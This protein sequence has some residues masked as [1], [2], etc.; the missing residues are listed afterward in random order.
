MNATPTPSPSPAEQ[1]P[2]TELP[3]ATAPQPEPSVETEA[4]VVARLAALK[5]MDYDRLR[6]EEAKALGIQVKTLDDLVKAA[7]G[8]ERAPGSM[9]FPEAEPADGPVNPAQVLDEV[10]A[11]IRRYVVLDLEQAH[12]AALWIAHTHLVEV[13]EVSPWPSSTPPS[14]PAPRHFSRPFSG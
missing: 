11:V 8:A 9:P 12:A 7:R 10:T 4:E 6:K 2:T 1:C 13:A 14:A 3:S 5:P